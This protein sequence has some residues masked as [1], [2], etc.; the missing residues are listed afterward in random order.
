MAKGIRAT[1]AEQTSNR[2]GKK[3]G[4]IFVDSS[5]EKEFLAPQGKRYA[6]IFRNDYSRSTWVYLMRKKSDAFRV[7]ER[8]LCDML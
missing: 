7:L 3:L 8:F 5:G 6:I 1:I 4:R 2:S